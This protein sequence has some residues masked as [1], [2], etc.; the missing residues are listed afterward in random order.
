[1]IKFKILKDIVINPT[2]S[3]QTTSKPKQYIP[4]KEDILIL[5]LMAEL[6]KQ[7]EEETPK[8][9][10]EESSI[11]WEYAALIVETRKNNYLFDIIK[12]TLACLPPKFGLYIIGS[13]FNQDWLKEEAEAHSRSG[14]PIHRTQIWCLDKI[15]HF[16]IKGYNE[17]MLSPKFW[18]MIKAQGTEKVLIF[19]PDG[20]P[21]RNGINPFINYDY[22]GAPW[23]NI[24]QN[25]D[26]EGIPKVNGVVGNGGLS[27]R[28]VSK[29]IQALDKYPARGWLLK[30]YPEDV[31][32]ASVFPQMGFNVADKETAME[33]SHEVVYDKLNAFGSHC[34]WR[35]NPE[36]GRFIESQFRSR[37]K[38][39]IK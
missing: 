22:I 39:E 19:Q 36:I 12:H 2:E 10:N 33:F 15:R 35:Y 34:G 14:L 18:Q 26:V 20:F 30:N 16:G 21:I 9:R 8:I 11:S 23:R 28:S 24:P 32:Y 27:L 17:L 29:M 13:S 3:K 38:S 6:N 37:L 25:F 1:M 31:Y 5:E 4:P 7:R